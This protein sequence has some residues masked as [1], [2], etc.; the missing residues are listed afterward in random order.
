MKRK[1]IHSNT[2]SNINTY[3]PNT[4][5][6]EQQLKQE[7]TPIIAEQIR[8]QLLPIIEEQIR[9]ELR[10]KIKK[11]LYESVQNEVVKEK[12]YRQYSYYS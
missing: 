11:E 8:K 4:F 5:H 2:N 10:I 3:T 9:Q 12:E 6:L 1:R 7:L